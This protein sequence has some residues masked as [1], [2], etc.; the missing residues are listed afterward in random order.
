MTYHLGVI[1]FKEIP[2]YPSLPAA[3]YDKLPKVQ[4]ICQQDSGGR[5]PSP[6]VYT[7]QTI[8]GQ[9][10]PLKVYVTNSSRKDKV[11]IC[12]I[13]EANRMTATRLIR[14][15]VTLSRISISMF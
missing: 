12:R 11:G 15:L 13:S 9:I 8:T 1:I 14:Q 4:W 7:G 6:K 2:R 10:T 5:K 3:S